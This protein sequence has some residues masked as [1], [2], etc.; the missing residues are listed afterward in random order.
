[1]LAVFAPLADI[2]AAIRADKLDLVVANKNAP[3]QSVLSGSTGQID[4]A[5]SAFADRGIRAVRLPVAAAFHSPLVA[6]AAGPFRAALDDIAFPPG[7]VPVYANTSADEYP[8]DPEATRDLL[9]HQLANPVAFADEVRAMAAA[10][11]RTFLEVGPRSVL[12]ALAT[13]TLTDAGVADATAIAVDGSA[14]RR[15]GVLDLGI[16]LA[17]L[18][19]RG[20]AVQLAE[21]EADGWCR[22]GPEPKPGMTVPVSGANVVSPR[23]VRPARPPAPIS[24]TTQTSRPSAPVGTPVMSE[25][26]AVPPLDPAALGPALKI[27]QETLTALQRMQEQSAQLHRQFL[28]TQEQAQ[29]TLFAL[30]HQQQGLLFP[31]GLPGAAPT[32]AP[33]PTAAVP[34]AAPVPAPP[35]PAAAPT[36]ALPVT[37]RAA[38]TPAVVPTPVT[39]APPIPTAVPVATPIA[40]PAA[41]A[42]T[43]AEPAGSVAAAVEGVLLEVVAEKT[44]YPVGMLDL[45]MAL[46]A[47]LGVDSIKRVEILSA[48]QE[49]LPDA[50]V[51]KPEHLGT[52]HTLRDVAAFLAAASPAPAS[53]ASAYRLAPAGSPDS[54]IDFDLPPIAPEPEDSLSY[55]DV[56]V[57]VGL[58]ADP[59]GSAAGWSPPLRGCCWRWWRRR[60][61]TRSGCSTSGW[62]W[63]PTSGSTR[64]SGSRSCP[65]SRSGCPTPRSSSPNTWAPSTPSAMSPPSSP[66]P[67]PRLH[68]PRLST[69][70]RRRRPSLP[71]PRSRHR[72]RPRKIRHRYQVRRM[73]LSSVGS[74]S[75]RKRRSSR[76]S[77][78]PA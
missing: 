26:S 32:V 55:P 25:P 39:S 53:P 41:A 17:R 61:D 74:C 72:T 2:E 66:P 59:A 30:V 67:A 44:G 65:P 68:P 34:V 1:M 36:V 43:V 63:T 15:P 69:K 13:A 52:L 4:R 31:A 51:V 40:P 49:R 24:T 3:G 62:P 38:P 33:V 50:P 77:N 5:E 56:P 45:G 18:A 28:E 64:S 46:D 47:D 57:D 71:R 14:G 27:T 60:R 12:T 48:L 16:A 29:R 8:A 42:P 76:A 21:W 78:R 37:P 9:G 23:P 6:E 19:A 54:K 75:A 10:G 73:I 58:A 35:V 11:V 22:P 20:H 7:T 70:T